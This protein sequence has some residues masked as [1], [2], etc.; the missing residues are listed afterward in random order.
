MPYNPFS[1]QRR[2]TFAINNIGEKHVPV[3]IADLSKI[4]KISTAHLQSV[5]YDYDEAIDK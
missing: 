1:Y 4:D 5:G 2:E 3:V